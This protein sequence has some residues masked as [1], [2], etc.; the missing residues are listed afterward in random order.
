MPLPSA[1]SA[2]Q[3]RLQFES[4]EPRI[5][6]SVDPIVS[7]LPFQS[8]LD[9]SSETAQ[10]S[11]LDA[12]VSTGAEYVFQD[13]GFDGQGQ[14]VAVIDSGIAWDHYALGSG[15]GQ[16]HRVVG[17]WD[18]AEGD[19]DPFDDGSAGYHGTHVAGII[20]SQDLAHRGVAP[21]VDLVGL[22][23]FDDQGMGNLEWVE[24]ALQWVHEHQ[25]DF[26]N[27]ITT[28]NLSL[29]V[30][31]NAHTLPQWA[32][33]EDEFSQLEADNIF[34][35]V[36]AGN[37]FQAY[38][39][40]GLA[41]PAVSEYVVPVASHDS[42]GSFSDFSQRSHRVIVAPGESI[43]SSV[44]GHLF[45][46]SATSHQYLSASGT[47]MAAPYVAGASTIVR[48]AMQFTGVENISQDLIADHFRETAD[49]FFDAATGGYYHRLN[50]SAAVDAIVQD[51]HGASAASATVL[52]ELQQS[53][54]IAGTIGKRMDTDTFQFTA[55]KTGNLA[56]EVAQSHQLSA[57]L[58]INGVSLQIEDGIANLNVQA[59]ENYL[60]SISTTDGLG[61]Y[62][63]TLNLTESFSAFD[64]GVI[65]QDNFANQS[66]AGETW[67]RL[68]ASH[69][70]IL[71]TTTQGGPLSQHLYD[72]S[73]NMMAQTNSPNSSSRLDAMVTGGQTY[74]L[75]VTGNLGRF[76]LQVDNLLSFG[77]DG[78]SIIGTPS[79]DNISIAQT[80]DGT[81]Q[82]LV[83]Q[84]HYEFSAN[85]IHQISVEGRGGAD[86]LNLDLQRLEDQIYLEG[87]HAYTH[88]AQLS[89]NAN[90]FRNILVTGDSSDRVTFLDTAGDD[91]FLATETRNT[92]TGIGY[93]LAA[94]NIFDVTSVSRQGHDTATLE[95]TSSSDHFIGTELHAQR[96]N[97]SGELITIGFSEVVIDGHS[98]FD[99]LVLHGGQSHNEYLLSATH[100]TATLS[101]VQLHA[102]NIEHTIAVAHHQTDRATIRGGAISE[103]L[104]STETTT[105]LTAANYQNVV[106]NS[107]Q[108]IVESG[109]GNDS[110]WVADSTGH[111][112]LHA[113]SQ[114]LLISGN[115]TQ[116]QFNGFASISV[117]AIH[118]G[119]DTAFFSGTDNRDTFLTKGNTAYAWGADY[120]VGILGFELLNIDGR[121]G[122]DVAI[123]HGDQGNTEYKIDR[124]QTSMSGQHFDISVTGFESQRLNGNTGQNTISIQGFRETDRLTAEGASLLAYLDGMA[125]RAENFI[126]LDAEAEEDHLAQREIAAVDFWYALQGEWAAD[127]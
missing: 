75:K 21:G 43:L 109:G 72:G 64:L 38:Q 117:D 11:L 94:A 105:I 48:Q 7:D 108:I 76:D 50:L 33:L 115:G 47:S 80:S 52:G 66:V 101:G 20:G 107:A 58:K 73:M 84:T 17:G 13:Y 26:E 24:Q 12:H 125:I 103:R 86:S 71:T 37:A 29:G 10:Y 51:A 78:L 32:T 30:D 118:G 34:I 39:T 65:S 23:V 68:T 3:R 120:H 18:F 111:D 60:L 54:E 42:D 102:E 49:R 82:I 70:G 5:V 45:G 127:P 19:A 1:N 93:S 106:L 126:W 112:E 22:R 98:G 110:G 61:H 25:H 53:Q 99:T 27:P 87:N 119:A 55:G 8:E 67:Y 15:L 83:A 121:G 6:F 124:E 16:G 89:I 97:Q 31:W 92:M 41:Y 69:H 9:A 2:N 81:I 123:L 116:R 74:F 44:P 85:H 35:S 57:D 4:F 104:Y 77:N 46:S 113:N 56:I 62:A 14:T 96:N 100:A 114:Q 36:A 79:A 95:G 28:V 63:V 40:P 90:H 59:G 122:N 91:E 88:N